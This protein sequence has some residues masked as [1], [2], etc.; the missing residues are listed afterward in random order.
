MT[1]TQTKTKG[2]EL[3]YPRL[4]YVERTDVTLVLFEESFFQPITSYN[5]R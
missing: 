4:F 1:E 5:G 2:I 3:K